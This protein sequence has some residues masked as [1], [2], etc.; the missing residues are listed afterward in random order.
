ME[1]YWIAFYIGMS[2][3]AVIGIC[4]GIF[5]NP[6]KNALAELEYIANGKVTDHHSYIPYD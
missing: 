2:M 3:F 6:I 4:A 1:H 5:A